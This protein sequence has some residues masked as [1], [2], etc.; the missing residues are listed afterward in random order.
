V[1]EHIQ[2]HVTPQEIAQFLSE[3]GKTR[4]FSTDDLRPLHRQS[5][6][7]R[8]LLWAREQTVKM[9]KKGIITSFRAGKKEEWDTRRVRYRFTELALKTWGL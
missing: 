1:A 7:R 2:K 9:L 4:N 3:S 6:R 8:S 5:R